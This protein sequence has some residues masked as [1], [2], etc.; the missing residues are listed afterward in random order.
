[1]NQDWSGAIPAT[2]IYDKT[3]V[4]KEVFIGKQSFD[5]FEKIVK[6]YLSPTE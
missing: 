1:M 4:Q 2:F 3:G 6:S 5:D